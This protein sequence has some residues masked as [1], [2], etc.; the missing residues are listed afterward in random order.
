MPHIVVDYSANMEDRVDM[1]AFCDVL[2]RAAIE[3]GVLPL[4]GVR[5]RAFRADHVSIADGDPAHGYIDIS[6][7]LRGG[8]ELATRKAAT[9]H[10][11]AAAEAFL[12]PAMARHSIALSFEMRDID[13]DLSPKTGTIRDHLKGRPE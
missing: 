12:A 5:V 4:A 13:P 6:L 9:A 8:R 11:F 3:T 1:A 10:V 7:R 2:R